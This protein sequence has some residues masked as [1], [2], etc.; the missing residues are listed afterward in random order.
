M[1]CYPSCP[2]KQSSEVAQL[3]DR[4]YPVD[5][6][7]VRYI[8]VL[9]VT[10]QKQPRRKSTYKK[11]EIAALEQRAA[12][13]RTS[14]VRREDAVSSGGN[15]AQSNGHSAS[16]PALP[17]MISQSM[18]ATQI[19]IPTVAFD[20]NW[21][22]LPRNLLQPTPSPPSSSTRVRSTSAAA[23]S[24][25]WARS[26]LHRPS[27]DDR[28]ANSWGATTV[29]KKLRNEVFN[30]AFL[31]QP[32]AVTKHRKPHQRSI[33]RR[34][35]QQFLRPS[36]SDSRLLV[37][38]EDSDSRIAEPKLALGPPAF[39][40]QTQSDLTDSVS[41]DEQEDDAPED[42]KDV[43]GT[44]APEPKTLADS[45][46]GPKKKR[47]YSGSGLRRKPAAV[48][49]SRGHLQYFEEADDVGYRG[50]GEDAS[51]L[52]RVTEGI[53]N[54]Q[55]TGLADMNALDLMTPQSGYPST[56]PSRAASPVTE[57]KPITRPINPKEAQMQRDSRVEYFLLLEDLTAGMKRPC[58]M[59]LKMGTRQY[60]VDA[61]PKKRKSQ[62]NKCAK[63]TSRELGVR[64]C[65]LQVWDVATESYVF[66]D[67]YYGRNLKAGHEF[68][69]AL[70]RFLYDGVD[71][72]SVLRHIPTVLHKLSQLEVIV[73]RLD[74]YRFYA[75]SLLMFYDGDVSSDAADF[76]TAVDDSTT[77]FATDTEDPSTGRDRRPRKN[78]RE[79]DFK[80][81]DFAN[82][83][84][85]SRLAMEKPCPPQHP[86]EPDRG[87]IRG[88]ATLR[89]YFRQIQRDVRTE[90]GLE[91]FR[92]NGHEAAPNY[93]GSDEEVS[94]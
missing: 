24:K 17:R 86:D 63:T 85:D 34:A 48:T 80:I 6:C 68:Q 15:S 18:Q 47:R 64:V 37:V 61:S 91:A 19:P 45:P 57:F 51:R 77:D 52:D 70:T 44:S 29:N 71:Y 81:A 59:D 26:S 27:L 49:E 10:F 7:S 40:G 55:H 83:V 65:G 78:P 79:I 1:T 82:S 35:M 32:V 66:K 23:G 25:P 72:T 20:N 93:G 11:D 39:I 42:V 87:F 4:P 76:D 16:Q 60:G 58:I 67:K 9:N 90:L 30:D 56:E 54:G 8:G 88:L 2:G 94:A 73:R 28:H 33:P 13:E 31:K 22:I 3:C 14:S 50:D 21:H 62:Q 36:V 46:A 69:D 12:E 5:A 41:R 74:G 43:T 84:T 53:V 75:A 92:R 38:R 89:K